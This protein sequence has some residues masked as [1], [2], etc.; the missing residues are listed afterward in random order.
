M[1]VALILETSLALLRTLPQKQEQVRKT[2]E[3][4]A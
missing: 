1:P 3:F 2:R 4:Y